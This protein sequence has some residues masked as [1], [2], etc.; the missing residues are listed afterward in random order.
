MRSRAER[1][2]DGFVQLVLGAGIVEC[3]YQFFVVDRP[4]FFFIGLGLLYCIVLFRIE[5]NAADRDLLLDR[6]LPCPGVCED[7]T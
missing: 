1:R 5:D 3:W 2:Q 7:R 6:D 4:A